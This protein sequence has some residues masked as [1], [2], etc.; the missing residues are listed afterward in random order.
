MASYEQI[1]Q[2]PLVGGNPALDFVNTVV[3]RTGRVGPD[4]LHRYEDLLVFFERAFEVKP[5]IVE[6]LSGT[7]ESNV[8]A[9]RLAM[10]YGLKIR[11]SIGRV[12]DDLAM[13]REPDPAKL[14]DVVQAAKR[15]Y[16]CRELVHVAD[17]YRWAWCVTGDL[18]LPVDAVASAAVELLLHGDRHARIRACPGSNC[19]WLFVDTS[20]NGRRKWCSEADCGASARMKRHRLGKPAK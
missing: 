2:L 6:H 16:G 18:A 3:S 5:E 14:D 10:S 15:S 7:A 11:D 17:G 12:F 19:G 4:L 8:P 9:A 1:D 13:A 20:K